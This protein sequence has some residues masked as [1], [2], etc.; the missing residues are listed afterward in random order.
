MKKYFIKKQS[1]MIDLLKKKRKRLFHVNHNQLD[2][3]II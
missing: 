2:L 1:T 3:F